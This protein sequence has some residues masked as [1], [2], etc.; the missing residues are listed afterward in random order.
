MYILECTYVHGQYLTKSRYR[1]NIQKGS[2]AVN[3]RKNGGIRYVIVS[4]IN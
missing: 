1:Y 4:K 3:K 2:F